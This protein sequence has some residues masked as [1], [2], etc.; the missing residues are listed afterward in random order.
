MLTNPYL[1]PLGYDGNFNL[2]WRDGVSFSYD[3][4]NRLTQA[5]GSGATMQFVYDGLGRCVK[6]TVN[7]AVTVI[8][9]DGWKPTVEWDGAGNFQAWNLYGAGE[10]EILWRYEVGFD[11]LRYHHDI[12]GNVTSVLAY[13]G[14]ILE[15]YSY[16]AFGKPTILSPD[17][18]PRSSS[19]VGNRFMFQGREWIPELGVYDYRHRMYQPDLGLFLQIDPM[20]LQTEGEKLGAGQKAF[21]SPGGVA[22]EAFTSS[23]MNLF[24]Y[25]GDDPV[26]KSDPMGLYFIVPVNLA[27]DFAEAR[28][29]ASKDPAI[30]RIF[31]AV[32][33]DKKI[34]VRVVPSDRHSQDRDVYRGDSAKRTFDFKWNP[35]AAVRTKT[36]GS[37]SPALILTHEVIHAERFIRDPMGM[38]RDNQPNSDRAFGTIEERRVF[39]IE[40]HAAMI[41]GEGVRQTGAGEPIPTTSVTSGGSPY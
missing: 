10:D 39:G 12:H 23:E 21:F 4:A 26:D 14:N 18:T 11:H 3:G 7:S 32:D 37:I 29:Y 6:R 15:R 35:R 9:Y 2:T 20:G 17:G 5:S 27:R 16:D 38:Q 36:N 8:A 30:K 24:R 31:D 1:L 22:P 41:L 25:C 28:E 19:G 40:N 33:A 34:G 13:A